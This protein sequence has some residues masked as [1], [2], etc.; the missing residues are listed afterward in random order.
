VQEFIV[1]NVRDEFEAQELAEAMIA[2]HSSENQ[3]SPPNVK[4]IRCETIDPGECSYWS[5]EEKQG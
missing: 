1:T 5:A 3:S 4:Q 2:S